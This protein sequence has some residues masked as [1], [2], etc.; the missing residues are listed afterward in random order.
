[1]NG[2][3]NIPSLSWVINLNFLLFDSFM[4]SIEL[5]GFASKCL[6]PESEGLAK[7]SIDLPSLTKKEAAFITQNTKCLP[8]FSQRIESVFGKDIDIA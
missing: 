4:R 7:Y 3:D 8:G 5:H 6:I 1:M 2:S